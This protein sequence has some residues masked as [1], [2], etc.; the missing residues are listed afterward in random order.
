M[1]LKFLL[2]GNSQ[3]IRRFDQTTSNSVEHIYFLKEAL[4]QVCF[5]LF[6]LFNCIY[7]SISLLFYLYHY[8]IKTKQKLRRDYV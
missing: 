4:V 2:T 8:V 6:M 7:S 1:G 3:E 5:S